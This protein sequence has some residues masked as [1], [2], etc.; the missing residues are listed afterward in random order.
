MA[1]SG[2]RTAVSLRGDGLDHV[3]CLV[4]GVSEA[5]IRS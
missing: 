4:D 1:E 3:C 2:L 5:A